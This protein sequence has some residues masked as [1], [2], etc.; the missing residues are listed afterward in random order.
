M[1]LAFETLKQLRAVLDIV[2]EDFD[3]DGALQPGVAGAVHF[4]HT[5]GTERRENLVGAQPSSTG[6]GHCGNILT[7]VTATLVSSAA[8]W[9][10]S[11][12]RKS[13]ADTA[14]WPIHSLAS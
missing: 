13:A 8:V 1:G 3:G 4:T 12:N 5:P 6:N 9:R 10:R 11:P 14:L 7:E 2:S